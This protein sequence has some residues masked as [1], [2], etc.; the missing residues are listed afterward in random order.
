MRL[1]VEITTCSPSRAGVGYYAEHLVD[2]LLETRSSGDDV[3]LLSNQRPAPELEARWAGHLRIRGPK[4]RAVWMQSEVP[5]LLSATGADVAV[6]PNYAVPLASPCPTIV[7]VHDMALFRAP[8]HFTLRKRL[9]MRSM[10]RRSVAAASVIGTV[11]VASKRDIVELLGVDEE[12]IVLLPGAAHPS[13][14]PAP[15]DVIASVRV[16]HGLDRP[17]VLTVGT[18]EPRKNLLTLLR[19]FDRLERDDKDHDL[20]VVGGRGWQD[21]PLVRALQERVKSRRVRWLGYV[22][23]AELAALYTGADLFVYTS[24]LEGFGLPVLEAM[25]CGTPVVASDIAALREVGGEAARYVPAEDD[26]AFAHAIAETLRDR[27]GRTTA[28]SK[29][30][31]RASDFSWARTAETLWQRARRTGPARDRRS[32]HAGDCESD[33]ASTFPLHPAPSSLKPREWGVLAAVVYADL[34]DTPLPLL[35]ARTISFGEALEEQELRRLVESPLL[36]SQLH[37]HANGFLVL[38]GREPLVT[39]MPEREAWTRELLAANQGTL[40]VLA[41]LPFVRALIVSGGVVH[42]NPSARPDI[43]LFVVAARGR[44]YTAYTWLVLATRLLGKRA[45]I[46][47]NYLVDEGELVVAYHRDLFT[48]HQ[49][50]SARPFSGRSSYDRWCRANEAWVKKIFPGFVPCTDVCSVEASAWQRA[51]ELALW[52]MGTALERALRAAWR[53]RLGPKR[54]TTHAVSRDVVLSDGVL[55]L[56]LSDYRT[57]VLSRFANRL[58]ALR[59]RLGADSSPMQPGLDSVG[60]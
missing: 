15:A 12:Q 49:L 31:A 39:K 36:S 5:R 9:L 59:D 26:V 43:D 42:K 6:F 28:R 57:R 23:E 25:A 55:K 17:Y 8:Q 29:G 30:P 54:R 44:V 20:V 35:D 34:F 33:R 13:C 46:C 2:A 51:S 11:S 22:P 38:P 40:S 10:L 21:A 48:A 50:V 37:L 41:E 32:L 53:F 47:P 52:P 1:A 56:H 7:V 58:Q 16:R 14:R 3:V 4:I 45:L 60:P 24:T 27:A 19:A 18:L